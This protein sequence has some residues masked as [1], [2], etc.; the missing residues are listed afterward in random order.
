MLDV[1]ALKFPASGALADWVKHLAPFQPS[2]LWA[3]HLF[4][5]RVEALVQTTP[6]HALDRFSLLILQA[7]ALDAPAHGDDALRKLRQRLHFPEAMLRQ[8]L[9][10]LAGDGLVAPE[11]TGL[12]PLGRAALQDGSY[13][14]P[15][16]QRRQFTFAERLDASGQRAAAPQALP[17]GALAG[18]AWTNPLAWDDACLRDALKRD[19]A[20]KESCGFP[21]D[22]VAL[23]DAAPPD[24]PAWQRVTLVRPEKAA[25]ILAR[26]DPDAQLLGFATQGKPAPAPIPFMQLPERAMAPANSLVSEWTPEPTDDDVRSAWQEWCRGRGVRTPLAE[27][28]PCRVEGLTLGVQA[29]VVVLHEMR[30]PPGGRDVDEWLLLGHGPMRRAVQIKVSAS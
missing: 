20:W 25:V 16:W 23:A 18:S 8:T 7:L 15:H 3:G 1:S 21:S 13:A 14:R 30:A 19:D 2:A 17:L 27:S 5:H 29:P 12:T 4:W 28:C 9:S 26:C 22:V 24:V 10:A 6:P 11:F